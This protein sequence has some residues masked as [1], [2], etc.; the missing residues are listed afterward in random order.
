MRL[1]DWL[2]S[3]RRGRGAGRSVRRPRRRRH[4]PA[5]GVAV[6]LEPLE[7]RLLLSA[8]QS[9]PGASV[10]TAVATLKGSLDGIAMTLRNTVSSQEAGLQS[11]LNQTST[12][13]AG[14]MQTDEANLQQTLVGLGAGLQGQING[15]ATTYDSGA[16]AADQQFNIITL[17]YQQSYSTTLAA[18]QSVFQSVADQ[19]NQTF[20]GTQGSE[21]TVWAAANTAA[22]NTF[23]A[24]SALADATF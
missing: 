2:S 13:L 5:R 16:Q 18:D 6:A 24:A 3:F 23:A 1:M 17:S 9:D 22:D 10:S 20:L 19:V 15:L 4:S 7:V 8:A 12:T 11:S 21:Q 14:Q